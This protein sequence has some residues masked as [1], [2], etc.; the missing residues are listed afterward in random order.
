M[1]AIFQSKI[2]YLPVSYKK[3]K[4]KIYKTVIL[5]VVLHGCERWSLTLGE[6][7]R[8]R[9]FEKRL[10]RRIFGPKREEYGSWRKL[11]NDELN[12]LYSSENI[13]RLIKSRR[14]SWDGHVAHVGERRGLYTVFVGRPEGKIPL[15][16]PR[17]I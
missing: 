9:V 4:I 15:V 8:L 16:R 12:Y 10:L 17:R 7:H 3:V 11:H 5:P 14:M 2:P 6:E 13:V 1:L